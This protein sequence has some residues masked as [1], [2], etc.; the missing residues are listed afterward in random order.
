MKV[1][2][3]NMACTCH[4][5]RQ[6]ISFFRK[7]LRYISIF[8]QIVFA[9]SSTLCTYVWIYCSWCHKDHEVYFCEHIKSI[10][11]DTASL[12]QVCLPTWYI[13]RVLVIVRLE[14]HHT[15]HTLPYFWGHPLCSY[16][17]FMQG[18][19]WLTAWSHYK[20][21]WRGLLHPFLMAICFRPRNRISCKNVLVWA[22]FY[23]TIY[24]YLPA[25]S[26]AYCKFAWS[27][28]G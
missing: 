19:I 26:S 8:R 20:N 12:L 15:S 7:R 13:L 18:K 11:L 28:W 23:G 24:D 21:R 3:E 10:L 5:S 27:M 17:T 9:T 4:Y 14:F 16:R 2:K 1:F 6:K 25:R 22:L